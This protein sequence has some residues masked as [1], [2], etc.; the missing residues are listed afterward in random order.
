M[1]GSISEQLKNV[2]TGIFDVSC[3]AVAHVGCVELTPVDAYAFKVIPQELLLVFD[4]Q[5]LELVL[6]GVPEIDADDWEKYTIASEDFPADLLKWFWDIVRGW[7]YEERAKLLQYATGSSRVPVQGFKALTSY[8]GR[9]C[10]FTLRAIPYDAHAFPRAH[11]CFNRID[12]PLYTSKEELE[13]HMSLVINLEVTGFT[14][15]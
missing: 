10:L 7:T 15:E 9:V 4:Y 3:L 12:L 5:E 6:C 14:D 11:T 13:T 1:L 2:M 8:D